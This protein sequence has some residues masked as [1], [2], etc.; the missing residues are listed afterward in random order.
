M[1]KRP[2]S[3][4]ILTFLLG[5]AAVFNWQRSRPVQAGP[6]PTSPPN[7]EQQPPGTAISVGG[8]SVGADTPNISIAPNQRLLIVYN[9]WTGGPS[10]RDPYFAVS[11]NGGSSWSSPAAIY[12]SPGIDSFH[13][14]ATY[15]TANT[16]HALWAE[17]DGALPLST[18]SLRY[19]RNAGSGWSANPATLS[20]LSSPLPIIV[21]PVIVAGANNNLD[22]VWAEGNPI[23]AGGN[24]NIYYAR[25]TD[26]GQTWSGKNPIRSTSPSSRLPSLA[27]SDD[28]RRHVVW[29][30][31]AVGGSTLVL[32][33]QGT[34]Q[35]SDLVWSTPITLSLGITDTATQP[36][37][38]ADGNTLHVSFTRSRT[39]DP[40]YGDRDQWVMYTACTADCSNLPNWSPRK[41]V[42]GEEDPVKVTQNTPFDLVSSLTTGNGCPFVFFHG[43]VPGT[44]D[45]E[46]IW[47]V[48]KCDN[49]AGG[50]RDRMTD[51]SMRGINPSVTSSGNRL[52][53]AYEWVAEPVHHVY[54]MS[55]KMQSAVYLPI[56]RRR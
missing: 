35:G 38:V 36:Q 34:L 32:Y 54:W 33:S 22:A 14:N 26:G 46:L 5:L 4:L 49:W 29:A 47:D 21:D 20:S 28:N 6:N 45:R 7:W 52:H 43:A 16:A 17:N 55:G 3:L 50:G 8:G 56:V 19:S 37:I 53:V 11:N 10:N 25:S 23:G 27:V 48:N 39:V 31:G 40:I 18:A 9:N 1:T 44:F 24:P 51:E 30:E 12:T 2:L 15:D 42:S 41:T 13:V